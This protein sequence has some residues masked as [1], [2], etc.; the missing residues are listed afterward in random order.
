M[1][2][3]ENELLQN[4]T[5]MTSPVAVGLWE[6]DLLRH[7]TVIHYHGMTSPGEVGC[8]GKLPLSRPGLEGRY[9]PGME[10]DLEKKKEKERKR[11]EKGG[12][13]TSRGL[14]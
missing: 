2:L 11:K 1:E 6:N 13:V 9:L 14:H 8:R 4:L 7:L 12:G 3:W 10:R 5:A